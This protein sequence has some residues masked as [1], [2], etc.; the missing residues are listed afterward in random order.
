MLTAGEWPPSEG[1]AYVYTLTR[2]QLPPPFQCKHNSSMWGWGCWAAG[3]WQGCASGPGCLP[4]AVS[5]L[6]G[7]SLTT[8]CCFCL[9]GQRGLCGIRCHQGGHDREG[10]GSRAGAL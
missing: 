2:A 7:P 8:L 3:P 4:A 10:N 1:C 9:A 5:V 6:Q